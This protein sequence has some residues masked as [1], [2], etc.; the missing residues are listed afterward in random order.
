MNGNKIMFIG[1]NYKTIYASDRHDPGAVPCDFD[2]MPGRSPI[3]VHRDM[4][5]STFQYHEFDTAKARPQQIID[6]RRM[7]DAGANDCQRQFPGA[8]ATGNGIL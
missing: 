7:A 2:Y 8:C 3:I 5:I 1:C 6:F 4:P